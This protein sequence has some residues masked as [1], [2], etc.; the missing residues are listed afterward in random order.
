MERPVANYGPI[1][2]RSQ[3]DS[4]TEPQ[5]FGR[6]QDT[7]KRCYMCGRGDSEFEAGTRE[8]GKRAM[9]AVRQRLAMEGSPPD[10]IDTFMAGLETALTWLY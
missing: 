4:D 10:A 3:P 6:D 9:L 7:A 1:P 2:T 5:P 8:G